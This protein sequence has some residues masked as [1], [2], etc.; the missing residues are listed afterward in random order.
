MKEFLIENI[1]SIIFGITTVIFSFFTLLYAIREHK[2]KILGLIKIKQKISVYLSREAL[3]SGL[4]EMYVKAKSD[5]LIWGQC[6]GCHNY[7]DDVK[8]VILDKASLGVKFKIIVNSNAPTLKEFKKI[9]D[10]IKSATVIEAPDNKLR[11]FGIS[12]QE[13]IISFSSIIGLTAIHIK[14][15]DFTSIIKEFFETRWNK[16]SKGIMK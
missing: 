16:Y 10:P 1:V 6:I 12:G 13:V 7:S 2:A 3:L 15:E 11:L 5:D 8:D 14:D 4:R 9:Y